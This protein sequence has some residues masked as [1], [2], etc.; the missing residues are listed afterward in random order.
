MPIL[1]SLSQVVNKRN[2]E[3]LL[4]TDINSARALQYQSFHNGSNFQK[5]D[6]FSEEDRLS[7]IPYID[8]FEECNALEKTQSH[9]CVLDLG[10]HSSTVSISMNIH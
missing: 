3:K 4:G 6:F 8:D 2:Q 10:K 1:Q 9:S 5:N 7:L